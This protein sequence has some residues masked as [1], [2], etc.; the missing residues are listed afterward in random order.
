PTTDAPASRSSV[1]ASGAV[2][3]TPAYM[4]PEQRGGALPDARSDQYSF[5]VVLHEALA[6]ERPQSATKEL[7]VPTRIRRVIVRGLSATPGDRYPS[8]AA[9]VDALER[10]PP[11][12]RWYVQLAVGVT[13]LLAL[14]GIGWR[15]AIVSDRRACDDAARLASK[16]WSAER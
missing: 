8:L 16:V 12:T 10:S 7:G 6:G 2:A 13:L 5:C 14:A 9:L 1:S 4:A 3:G 11:A 15:R